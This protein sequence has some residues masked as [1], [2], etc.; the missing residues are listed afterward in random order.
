M[1]TRN[2][3]ISVVAIIT[4]IWVLYAININNKNAEIK[5]K[6][7]ELQ[8]QI[9][10]TEE[11]EARASQRSK[12][13]IIQEQIKQ[14][15]IEEALYE[16]NLEE[17]KELLIIRQKIYESHIWYKRCLEIEWELEIKNIE[18]DLVC[19]PYYI[20]VTWITSDEAYESLKKFASY[21]LNQTRADLGL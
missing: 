15:N 11:A 21:N 3:I 17:A 4:L 16:K 1:K 2:L 20:D 13:E 19:Y 12:I 14:T 8:E 18:T 5:A 6:K 7:I 10:K 9:K